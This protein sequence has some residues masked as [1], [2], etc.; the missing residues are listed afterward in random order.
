MRSASSHRSGCGFQLRPPDSAP[1]ADRNQNGFLRGFSPDLLSKLFNLWLY[2]AHVAVPPRK[3]RTIFFPKKSGDVDP[4]DFRPSTISSCFLRLFHKIIAAG[5]QG[6]LPYDQRH[7]G[8]LPVD[9]CLDNALIMDAVLSHTKST[10]KPLYLV[11]LDIAMAFHSGNHPPIVRAM[12]ALGT[13]GHLCRYLSSNFD[14]PS[15]RV[16]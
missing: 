15:N 1:G 8:F 7:K 13:P 12:R 2:M 16:F 5:L 9:G 10:I 3:S 6:L 11:Y 14:R 4:K